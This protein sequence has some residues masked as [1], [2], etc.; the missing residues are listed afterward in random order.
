MIQKKWTSSENDALQR[1]AVEGASLY[2]ISK[3]LGRSP[4]AVIL[5]TRLLSGLESRDSK[6]KMPDDYYDQTKTISQVATEYG[7][8]WSKDDSEILMK[9]FN[10][11]DNIYQLAE[12]F[13]R[14]PNAII[15]QL[16][17]L[18]SRPEEMETL[19][20]RAKQF[21]G[22]KKTVRQGQ[23]EQQ[24]PT[25]SEQR[26]LENEE[27]I[28]VLNSMIQEFETQINSIQEAID[29]KDNEDKTIEGDIYQEIEKE[30]K[31]KHITDSDEFQ[32]I[33]KYLSAVIDYINN[34]ELDANAKL[35]IGIEL[36]KARLRLITQ[37]F[38]RRIR[39]REM[40][41]HQT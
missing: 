32:Q 12:H 17:K 1:M 30:L 34:T 39:V 3:A 16:A 22:K 14:T 40:Y 37:D 11:G 4:I 13:N 7:R 31:S 6:R 20:K 24:P 15:H 8:R 35:L 10:D 41:A 28:S 23:E 2:K 38:N 25:L 36:L 21:F 9:R 18:N 29:I 27:M 19:F 26:Q 33:I 5:R